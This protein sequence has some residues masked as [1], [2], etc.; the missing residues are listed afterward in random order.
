MREL[1]EMYK[2]QNLTRA[3][4]SHSVLRKHV[5]KDE[6]SPMLTGHSGELPFNYYSK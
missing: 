2:N 5:L 4:F 3:I 1:L 6:P